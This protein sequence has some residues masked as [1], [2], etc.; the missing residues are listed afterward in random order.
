MS[1]GRYR[2]DDGFP[3]PGHQDVG[4]NA[5]VFRSVDRGVRLTLYRMLA[6]P[7]VLALLLALHPWTWG[8]SSGSGT[9]DS[10]DF[11]YGTPAPYDTATSDDGSDSLYPTDD[12][13][14]DTGDDG[15]DP[16]PTDDAQTEAE[17]LDALISQSADARSDVSAAVSDVEQC[18]SGLSDDAGTFQDAADSRQSLAEQA[19]ELTMDEVDGGSDAAELLSTALAQS[20]EA[21]AD[22]ARWAQALADGD[23]T[24]GSTQNQDDFVAGGKDSTKA[25]QDKSDFVDTWNPIAAQYQLASRSPDDF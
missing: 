9:S 15:S 1:D 6:V 8:G 25:Q 17:A 3:T 20:A 11:G 23:C 10:N 2:A 7:L 18:G 22:Y 12:T 19:Q 13:T 16:S 14:A 24:P 5:A 4:Y 21:D